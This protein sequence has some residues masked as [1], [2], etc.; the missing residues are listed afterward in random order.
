M[1]MFVF[2]FFLFV[3]IHLFL[4]FCCVPLSP[5]LFSNSTSLWIIFPRLII[6]LAEIL[7]IIYIYLY[8]VDA[9]YTNKHKHTTCMPAR[10]SASFKM[11]KFGKYGRWNFIKTVFTLSVPLSLCR[12]VCQLISF[13]TTFTAWAWSKDKLDGIYDL[14]FLAIMKPTHT[15][16]PN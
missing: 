8:H 14:L 10:A 6:N 1:C 13:W 2:V 5:L 7:S 9:M 15:H 4:Y 16:T 11:I 3:N 12:N